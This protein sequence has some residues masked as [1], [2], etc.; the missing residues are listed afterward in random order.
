[1]AIGVPALLHGSYNAFGSAALG[2]VIALVSVL[3]LNL[4]LAK[5]VDFE[6]LLRGAQDGVEGSSLIMKTRF[7]T[8]V[9]FLAVTTLFAAMPGVQAQVKATPPK[10]DAQGLCRCS[11]K[12]VFPRAGSCARG[13]T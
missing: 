3:A 13:M 12:T 6:R 4:Y 11:R 8:H 1:V 7:N 5:S 9:M 2:L 10:A